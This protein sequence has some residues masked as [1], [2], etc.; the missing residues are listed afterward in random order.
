MKKL[1]LMI[2]AFILC[3]CAATGDNPDQQ[4]AEIAKMNTKTL[5][6]V[7]KA[8]PGAMAKIK[9]APGYATFS[10][11]QVNLLFVSAGVGYGVVH[12]NSTGKDTYM[13]MYEG[14]IGLGL[15]AK[16]FRAVF[17]F[18]TNAAMNRFTEEGWAFGAEA[19][20]AA[21]AG[22]KG[23]QVGGGVTI[24]DI[25]VYQ[26]TAAGLALQATLKGTR[27]VKNEELN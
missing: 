15:G 14:G 22:D 9:S 10:N 7:E 20:A 25:T 13:D 11:A 23:G 8:S 16:D 27:Y 5:A 2:T 21:K 4:R 18:N 12:N 24:G 26:I 1:L 19:D 3:A 17:V 6:D